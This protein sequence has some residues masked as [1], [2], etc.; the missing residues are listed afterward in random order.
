MAKFEV[1]VSAVIFD[2]QNRILLTHRRD[3]D[4]WDLPGGGMD[5]GELPTEAVARE[6][7]EETGLKVEVE[8]LLIVGVAPEQLLGFVYLCRPTGG[9]MTT[10]DESDDVHFFA[11]NDLPAMLPPRKRAIIETV[12]QTP[13]GILYR[14][15]TQPQGRQWYTEEMKKR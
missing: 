7:K 6:A 15:V 9:K 3:I 11:P 5:A 1:G 8:R 2:D 4:L 12:Y 10:T 13:P 14:H